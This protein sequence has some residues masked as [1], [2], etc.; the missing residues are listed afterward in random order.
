M[1]SQRCQQRSSA[2]LPAQSRHCFQDGQ[3]RLA[4]AVVLHALP[5]T[6]A[7]A[8][9]TAPFRSRQCVRQ[10][11]DE[12][13]HEPA[14]ADPRLAGYEHQLPLPRERLGECGVQPLQFCL[15]ADDRIAR[16]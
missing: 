5:V 14:L 1:L 9:G 10:R 4:G 2:A 11:R 7:D 8:G 12:V 3:V 16:R 13:V 6:H 15:A